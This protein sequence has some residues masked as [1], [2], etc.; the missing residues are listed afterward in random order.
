LTAFFGNDIPEVS[1]TSTTAPGVTRKWKRLSD[2]SDE[3]MVARIYGGFHY[4][5]SGKVAQEMG[6]KIAE[7]TL[8][9]Q[10]RSPSA[11]AAPAR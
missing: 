9:T 7:Q 1:M 4:R 11:S 5:F 2:Y 6:R 3:V 8:A 10:L